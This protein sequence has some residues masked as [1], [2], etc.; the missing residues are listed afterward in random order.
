M[1]WRWLE[2]D[3]K[4]SVNEEE[5]REAEVRSGGNESELQQSVAGPHPV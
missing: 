5:R 3:E 4:K 2:T 1:T